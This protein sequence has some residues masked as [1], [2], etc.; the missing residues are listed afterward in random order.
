VVAFDDEIRTALAGLAALRLEPMA[1]GAFGV[2][3]VEGARPRG[4]V[5]HEAGELLMVVAGVCRE[6]E[7]SPRR[8]LAAAA[9][10]T[11]GCV[12]LIKRKVVLR[13]ALPRD[14]RD[15]ASIRQAVLSISAAARHFRKLVTGVRAEED[16]VFLHYDS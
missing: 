10:L 8:V 3:W 15:A 12:A 13:H 5:V 6:E 9:H 2:T 4:V 14:R 7:T 1:G 11:G 16:A